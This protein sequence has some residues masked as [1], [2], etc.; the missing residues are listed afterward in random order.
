MNTGLE[1]AKRLLREHPY[2][3]DLYGGMASLWTGARIAFCERLFGRYHTAAR[4]DRLFLKTSDPWGYQTD[5]ISERRRELILRALPRSRYSRLL[6]IGCAEGWMTLR[7]AGRADEVIAVDISRVALDRASKRCAGLP[8][9]R[10]LH[11]DLL[12]DPL[13]NNLDAILCAG[14]LVFLPAMVQCEIRDR[15]IDSLADGGDLILEHT[16][17]AYP[18]EIAGRDIHT[19][20]QRHPA[21]SLTHHEEV[22]NY[23]ITTFR[24]V[25][26]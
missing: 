17:M 6:E 26:Q 14:V 2:T 11:L 21:L 18:G 25:Q 13:F 8:N 3:S 4:F 22:G 19:L 24:K 12:V 20:Y 23:A 5:P 7:L 1:H 16:T 10:F 9:V 15:M